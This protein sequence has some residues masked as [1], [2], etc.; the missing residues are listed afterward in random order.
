MKHEKASPDLAG[1]MPTD[2]VLVWV[3]DEDLTPDDDFL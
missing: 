2:G 3:S 1:N